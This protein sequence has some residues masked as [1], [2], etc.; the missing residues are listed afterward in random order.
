MILKLSLTSSFR[1]TVTD[2]LASPDVR[3]NRSILAPTNMQINQYNDTILR[4][5]DGEERMYLAAGTLKESQESGFL[6]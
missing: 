5:I 2:I 6:L 1:Q 3:V 4:R